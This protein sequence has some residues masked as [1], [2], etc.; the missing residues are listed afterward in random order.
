MGK[1]KEK[2]RTK[3]NAKAGDREKEKVRPVVLW[4]RRYL[5]DI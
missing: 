5:F 3:R 1:Q 4:L 2:K